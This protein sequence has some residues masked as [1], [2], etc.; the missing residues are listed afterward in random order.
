MEERE[1]GIETVD[2]AANTRPTIADSV[3]NLMNA[4]GMIACVLHI[5]TPSF[6]I[7]MLL[8]RPLYLRPGKRKTT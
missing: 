6:K 1:K 5:A 8:T 3:V 4:I 7:Y 2:D